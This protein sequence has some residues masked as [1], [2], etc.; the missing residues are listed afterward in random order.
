[1]LLPV[2][3]DLYGHGEDSGTPP[4]LGPPY[5]AATSSRSPQLA[6]D[7]RKCR[8]PCLSL[9]PL[10]PP[11]SLVPFLSHYLCRSRDA[12][13]AAVSR[14]LPLSRLDTSPT[15]SPPPVLAWRCSHLISVVAVPSQLALATCCGDAHLCPPPPIMLGC[16]G[17]A[18]ALGGWV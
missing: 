16:R 9:L 13:M 15:S 7:E 18:A 14:S 6:A 5:I 17:Q 11:L 10:L 12:A 4:L 3:L 8:P 1:M 2:D